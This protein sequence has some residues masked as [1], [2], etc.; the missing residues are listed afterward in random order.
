MTDPIV[1]EFDLYLAPAEREMVERA[2]EFGQRVVAPGAR[3]WE[4]ERRHPTEALRAACAEGF[5]GIELSPAFG[6]R[7]LR[8]STK[9]RVAEE[10]ARYDFGFA[11]SL[12]NHHNV[13]VRIAAGKSALA[14]RLVPRM[15]SGE[16]IGCS[17]FTE[18]G[19]GSDLVGLTTLATKVDGGWTLSGEK[20]WICNAAVADV[21]ITLAQTSPVAGSKGIASFIVEADRPG[22]LRQSAY[23]LHGAHAI[24][25]AGFRLEN[26]FAP[27]NALLDPPGTAFKATLSGINGA[28]CYVAAMCAGMLESAI[29]H[30][31][32]YAG[33]RQAFG[34]KVIEFQGLRW[35]LVDVQ[36]DLAA[37]RL[38]A[39]R[40]AR[41][42]DAGQSA[43]E[44]A[45][46]AKKFAGDR[47]IGH[48]A[49]CIQVMG[50]NGLRSDHPLMR[51]LAAAKT[52]CFTDG[53]TEMMN[54]RLGKLMMHRYLVADV[55]TP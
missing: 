6:G 11:F 44:S 14:E 43:E 3:A 47:T 45:A 15:L 53:T 39:Y 52:A 13:T 27:D 55:D 10:L 16:A 17:A 46:Y 33:E 32:R 4:Y 12:L 22:F 38:L 37:M 36:T 50:A 30:A 48:I 40:A 42:I 26:Y 34:R 49:A 7:G 8:F 28:R 25:V 51:H 9:M 20:A 1:E 19:H 54:E 2:K 41:Q 35:S 21:I 5:C 18:P 24:G 29:G 31:V 23:A